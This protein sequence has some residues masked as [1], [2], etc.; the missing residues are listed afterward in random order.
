MKYMHLPS[1][2]SF[3]KFYMIS[4]FK[5]ECKQARILHDMEAVVLKIDYK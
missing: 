5:S 3:C 2:F 1:K 4:D